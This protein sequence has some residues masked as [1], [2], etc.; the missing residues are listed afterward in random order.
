MAHA[1]IRAL[2]GGDGAGKS[3][4]IRIVSGSLRRDAG[5]INVAGHSDYDPSAI[6]IIFQEPALSSPICPSQKT[7]ICPIAATLSAAWT[8]GE[9]MRLPAQTPARC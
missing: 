8:S 2:L 4:L 1:G 9:C 3:T 7:S 6:K 5:A